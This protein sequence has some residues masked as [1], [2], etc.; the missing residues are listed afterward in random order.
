VTTGHDDAMASRIGRP[1]VS[2]CDGYTNTEA[3]R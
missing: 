3:A 1:N 2:L